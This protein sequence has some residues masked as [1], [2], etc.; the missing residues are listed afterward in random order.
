MKGITGDIKLFFK[1]ITCDIIHPPATVTEDDL[2]TEIKHLNKMA[3]VDGIIV[4]L[5]V[6]DHINARTVCDSVA[7]YKDVDGFG[8]I[9]VGRM[10]VSMPSYIPAAPAAVLE[11]IK[12]SGKYL[13]I[14]RDTMMMNT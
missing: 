12:Q 10:G 13:I 4:Q 5:P 14:F 11:I 9:N 2:L 6:P 1:G 7:P 8:L 3:G